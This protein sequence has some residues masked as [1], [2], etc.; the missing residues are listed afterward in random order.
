M[1][2]LIVRTDRLG[3][4]L[5]T[6]PMASAIKQRIP[7]AHITMMIREY[8]L[9]I[10]KMCPDVDEILTV[11]TAWSS[12]RLA[13]EMRTTN[14]DVVF[15]PSPRTK[16]AFAVLFSGISKR[17]GTGYRWYSFC[18]NKK[19]YDHR[20]TAEHNEAEYNVR[21]LST[22]GITNATTPLPK[23]QLS[24][25]NEIAE[26][27]AVLH[28]LTGGSS[29][30]WNTDGFIT[31]ASWLGR[32][33]NLPIVLTGEKKDSEFFFTVTAKMKL[34]GVNVHIQDQLR[35]E[36]LASTLRDATCV[37]A[38]ATG[39]GHLA[40]A[41]GTPTV[42]LFPLA[43]SISKERWG[44]RGKR[45]VNIAPS[46]PVNPECPKCAHCTCISTITIDSVKEALEKAIGRYNE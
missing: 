10:V 29:P 35:L 23:L 11:D 4:M 1:K 7:G 6:L 40:A 42:G 45:V 38:G 15:L 21:M 46:S 25:K 3:D 39:P 32:A 20:K 36:E 31:I 41:L 19:T 27:Y 9:P 33:K 43:T 37:V 17:V 5:L 30:A 12:F 24:A 34:E 13:K 26:P 8:T 44:F 28:L 16:L 22:I 18:F 2:I 14:A